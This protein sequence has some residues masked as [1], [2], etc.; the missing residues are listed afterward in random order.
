MRAKRA[1]EQEVQRLAALPWTIELKPNEEGGFFA[2]IVEVP[3]CMTEGETE[4]EAV[5]NL[6]ETLEVWLQSELEQGHQIP[7]PE[8][9]RYSGTFTVRTSPWLHRLAAEAAQRENVSLNEFVNEAIA[10]AAGG[11]AAF[12]VKPATRRAE[13]RRS[14][15]R[16]RNADPTLGTNQ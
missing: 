12:R 9:K 6:K 8:S 15:R 2:R 1:I 13:G 5:Q 7:T 11:A 3:G 14:E 4:I 10:F 16:A